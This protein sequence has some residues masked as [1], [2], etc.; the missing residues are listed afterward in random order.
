MA[1]QAAKPSPQWKQAWHFQS[2]F[3]TVQ[4]PYDTPCYNMYSDKMV[5]IRLQS[6]TMEF[7]K[8]IE[9]K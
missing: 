9:G 5:V 2:V 6:F 7:Y 8:G 4:P 3:N 1:G